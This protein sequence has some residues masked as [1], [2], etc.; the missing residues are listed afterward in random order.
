MTNEDEAPNF[1]WLTVDFETPHLVKYVEVLNTG[2][3]QSFLANTELY[4]GEEKCGAFGEAGTFER[5][6]WVKVECPGDGIV[7]SGFKI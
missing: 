1:A 4:I 5:G 2:G 3:K 6:D 7:G